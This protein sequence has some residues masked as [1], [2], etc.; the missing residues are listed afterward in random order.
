MTHR[1]TSLHPM[2]PQEQQPDLILRHCY[3]DGPGWW[4][5]SLR[6]SSG[7]LTTTHAHFSLLS[8]P[9]VELNCKGPWWCGM[10]PSGTSHGPGQAAKLA[11]VAK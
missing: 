11:M 2:G 3:A 5:P 10:A 9:L 1:G 8:T 7:G 6:M 4:A